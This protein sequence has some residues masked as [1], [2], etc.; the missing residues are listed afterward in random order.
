MEAM[1]GS[2]EKASVGGAAAPD[3]ARP[4]AMLQTNTKKMK[5]PYMAGTV[6]P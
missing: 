3:S 1:R 5:S 2:E 4:G 6:Y